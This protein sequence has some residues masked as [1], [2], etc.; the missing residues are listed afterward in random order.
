MKKR[1][2]LNMFRKYFFRGQALLIQCEGSETRVFVYKPREDRVRL[3]I[4]P[5]FRIFSEILSS[6]SN[7]FPAIYDL[8][9]G[10]LFI[11]NEETM[12]KFL[13]NSRKYELLPQPA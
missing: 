9:F 7:K 11:L 6:S 5:S 10:M 13:K 4:F 12:R 8:P 2:P 3:F 1:D